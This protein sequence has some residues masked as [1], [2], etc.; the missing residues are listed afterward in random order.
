MSQDH[1]QVTIKRHVVTRRNDEAISSR[2]FTQ[3]E[4]AT[5]RSQ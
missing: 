4:I 3:D 5:L 1:P 2:A